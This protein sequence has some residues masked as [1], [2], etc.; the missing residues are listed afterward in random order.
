MQSFI[1]KNWRE[2]P[3]GAIEHETDLSASEPMGD[4]TVTPPTSIS[5]Q[6]S[7]LVME[8]PGRQSVK[9]EDEGRAQ[10]WDQVTWPLNKLDVNIHWPMTVESRAVD[11]SQQ[12]DGFLSH[13]L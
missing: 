2:A 4:I 9:L 11:R 6:Q 10:R 5:S 13:S 3:G 7:Q 12:A 8:Q 1:F